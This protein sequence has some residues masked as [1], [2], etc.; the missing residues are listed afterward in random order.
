MS[1]NLK[2][3]MKIIQHQEEKL[4]AHQKEKEPSN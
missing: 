1:K 4:I 2:N 3:T